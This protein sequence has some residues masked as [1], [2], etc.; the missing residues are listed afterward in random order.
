MHGPGAQDAY[1]SDLS[2]ALNN[3]CLRVSESAQT[4]TLS[5]GTYLVTKTIAVPHAATIKGAGKGETSVHAGQECKPF[6]FT[7]SQK[8]CIS[9]LT[10]HGKPDCSAVSHSMYC[11]IQNCRLLTLR[12]SGPQTR[13]VCLL[14]SMQRREL[15]KIT[16]IKV[17]LTS[18]YAEYAMADADAGYLMPFRISEV[19]DVNSDA[20]STVQVQCPSGRAFWYSAKA[21]KVASLTAGM[22]IVSYSGRLQWVDCEIGPCALNGIS[23]YSQMADAAGDV[24][25]D[26]F[27]L[28]THNSRCVLTSV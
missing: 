27:R 15:T 2:D 14:E 20:L 13:E 24:D 10:L 8:A 3:A 4:V 11:D 21:V 17:E 9:D 22:A 23:I 7:C 28:S 18:D 6:M 19:V 25:D 16:G 5:A 26:V 1:F 12:S